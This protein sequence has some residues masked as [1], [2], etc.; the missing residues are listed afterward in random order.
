MPQNLE[1]LLLKPSESLKLALE[2]SDPN[3]KENIPSADVLLSLVAD[4]TSVM[5]KQ[6]VLEMSSLNDMQSRLLAADIDYFQSILDEL[7]LKITADLKKIS[8]LMKIKSDTFVKE[9]SEVDDLRIVAAVR[10][11]RNIT[12]LES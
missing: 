8:Q 11:I 2:T 1:P 10:Q 9:A 3:Y 7:G 5:L 4:E 6:K 12:I